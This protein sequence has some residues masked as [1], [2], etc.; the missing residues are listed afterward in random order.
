MRSRFFVRLEARARQACLVGAALCALVSAPA[1]AQQGTAFVMTEILDPTT[2]SSTA[3][4]DFGVIAP[5]ASGGTVVLT[6]SPTPTCTTTNGLVRTGPCKA[7]LF[8]G[9]TNIGGGL[10]VMRPNGNKITLT[11]PSGAT[12][13]VNDFTFGGD[14]A[15]TVYTGNNGA[16]HHFDVHSADG[17]YSFYV[18]GRLVVGASQRPGVYTGTFEVRIIYN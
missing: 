17:A 6:A 10:R 12:M 1:A 3:D 9:S 4:L 15:S 8:T 14:G 13:Q 7:A 18:G 11:G 5:S 16:N 2:L